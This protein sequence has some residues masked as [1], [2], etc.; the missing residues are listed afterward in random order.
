MHTRVEESVIDEESPSDSVENQGIYLLHSE[1]Y[2]K[3]DVVN[4]E[5][6]E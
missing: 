1:K 4:E 3:V 6:S 2:V 5:S